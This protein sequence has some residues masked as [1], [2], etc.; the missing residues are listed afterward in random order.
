M[1]Q[2]DGHIAALEIGDSLAST[3]EPQVKHRGVAH[4]FLLAGVQSGGLDR[5]QGQSYLAARLIRNGLQRSGIKGDVTGGQHNGQCAALGGP[6]LLDGGGGQLGGFNGPA[7]ASEVNGHPLGL[8]DLGQIYLLHSGGRATHAGGNFDL[9]FRVGHGNG[10]GA[11]G[12]AAATAAAAAGVCPLCVNG[13]VGAV[14]QP[15]KE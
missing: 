5:G 10:D 8:I 2:S 7:Q 15:L 1:G 6:D 14:Y 3:K 12:A 13:G 11:A 9:V 4:G